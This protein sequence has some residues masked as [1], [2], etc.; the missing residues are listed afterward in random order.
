MQSQSVP[1]RPWQEGRVWAEIGLD[2]LAHNVRILKSQAKGAALLA[3][4][5]ANAYGHG[6]VAMARAA[7]AASADRLGVICVDEGEQ[8]R[9]AG[10]TAPILV[11][12]HTSAEEARRRAE[13]FTP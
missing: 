7:V 8:L 12:G 4:V 6:A 5:K 9:R 3:V 13:S 2:A 10:I 1:S 11:M